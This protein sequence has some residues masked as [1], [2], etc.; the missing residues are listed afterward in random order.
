MMPMAK[1]PPKKPAPSLKDEFAPDAW[2]RF[3]TLIRSAAKMGHQLHKPSP[4][5]PKAAVK[6]ARKNKKAG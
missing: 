4:P 3:E 5:Q 1:S 6:K 2:E